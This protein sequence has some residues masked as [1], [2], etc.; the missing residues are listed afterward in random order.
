MLDTIL[1]LLLGLVLAVPL[2]MNIVGPF[3]VWKTQKIPTDVQ[4]EPID[5]GDFAEVCSGEF[6]FYDD[7]IR[8]LGFSEVGASSMHDTHTDSY[9]RLYWH[10]GLKVAGM[11]VCID[12]LNQPVMTYCEFSQKYT[13]DSILDVSNSPRPEGYPDLPVK[14][15]F[16]FPGVSDV[17]QLLSY[18]SQLRQRLK[19]NM[20]PVDYPVE[21]GFT[22][23]ERFFR[24]ESDAL[25]AKGLLHPE[26]GADGKRTLTL[27]GALTMTWRAVLPGRAIWGFITERR[28]R[29]ILQ[30]G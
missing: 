19:N 23:I 6:I 27:R 7:A 13:D 4:F 29:K 14:R 12:A 15:S 20:Q 21:Q 10:S 5:D 25:L 2:F 28:G 18:H 22:E 9:F 8:E 1:L 30:E 16:R 24:R 26:V 17:N 3:I 11:V